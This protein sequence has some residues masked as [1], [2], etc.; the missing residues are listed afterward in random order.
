VTGRPRS[1]GEAVADAEEQP[2]R[3]GLRKNETAG[4]RRR[5]SGDGRGE[6]AD[7][8]GERLEEREGCI[9]AGRAQYTVDGSD[10]WATEPDV[11]RVAYGI[12]AR[13]DRLRGLGNAIVPQIA[14]WIGRR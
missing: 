4:E 7:A 12:P 1:G 13:V 8:N 3:S 10:W 2:Q 14:E 11:G 5:R 6:N 9:F